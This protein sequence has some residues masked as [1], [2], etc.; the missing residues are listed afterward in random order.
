MRKVAALLIF[1]IMAG[2][3]CA[4]G[5]EDYPEPFV[6]GSNFNAR[7]VVG[8]DSPSGDVLAATSIATSLQVLSPK[9]K[10]T[11]LLESETINPYAENLILIGDC[12]N[13]GLIAEVKGDE[14]CYSNL[15]A[16]I[17]AIELTEFNDVAVLIVGGRDSA[18]RRKAA[19][20]L[21]KYD[22]LS[23]RGDSVYVTG[24]IESPRLSYELAELPEEE[25]EDEVEVIISTCSR[26][27]DCP[28]LQFCSTFGCVDIECPN[29]F[30]A[31]NHS[32][33]KEVREVAEIVEKI[34]TPLAGNETA[35]APQ[36]PRTFW[37]NIVNWFKSLFS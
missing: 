19:T 5:L 17:G 15:G 6:L 12:S 36:S 29:G 33:T 25:E 13:N 31:A 30:T 16:G 1:L 27:S 14:A 2:T 24:T 3:A 4:L 34:A 37:D 11:A 10:I 9:E 20:A 28:E 7:M 21:T 35:L 22:Y 23:F 8:D 18:G 32:C 26:D